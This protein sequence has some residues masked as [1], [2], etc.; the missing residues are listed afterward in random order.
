MPGILIGSQLGQVL[1]RPGGEEDVH[2]KALQLEMPH[3]ILMCLRCSFL[4]LATIAI[5]LPPQ[6]EGQ[7]PAKTVVSPLRD[8]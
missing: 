4:T 2:L 8:T 1:M 5:Q 6:Y 7:T 3:H